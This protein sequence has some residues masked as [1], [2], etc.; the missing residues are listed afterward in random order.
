MAL[1]RDEVGTLQGASE[2]LSKMARL[3]A[4][5]LE[6]L[7]FSKIADKQ[8]EEGFE[9]SDLDKYT[10]VMEYGGKVYL[11]P[12]EVLYVIAECAEFFR[13]A[14]GG[15][16]TAHTMIKEIL[17]YSMARIDEVHISFR[18]AGLN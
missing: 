6:V 17:R 9:E 11:R 14:G 12:H 4:E 13:N 16:Y 8:L 3:F 10:P 15:R 18:P 2:A 1:T 5:T 7:L